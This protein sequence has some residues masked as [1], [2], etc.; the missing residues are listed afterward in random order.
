MKWDFLD[1]S[2]T[3]TG[4]MLAVGK[5]SIDVT[6]QFKL[7]NAFANGVHSCLWFKYTCLLNIVRRVEDFWSRKKQESCHI[8]KLQNIYY[9]NTEE[10]KSY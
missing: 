6:G 10:M 5:I 7:S 3:D 8:I 4:Y 2:Q 1:T 9:M